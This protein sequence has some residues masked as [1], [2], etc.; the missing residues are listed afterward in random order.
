[1]TIVCSIKKFVSLIKNLNEAQKEALERI[2]FSGLLAMPEITLQRKLCIWLAENFDITSQ[3][4]VIQGKQIPITISDV[5]SIMG[6]PS[7]GVEISTKPALD[8]DDYK[9]YAMYKDSRSSNISLGCLQEAILQDPEA[10]EHFIRRMVLFTIGYI[11]C[12]TTKPYVS[13]DYLSLVKD[14]DK[15]K[16]TNWS[17]LTRDFLLKSLKSYKEGKAN[18]E[19]NLP[20]L[21]FWFWEHVHV[22]EGSYKLSYSNRLPPLM[23]YWNEKNVSSRNKYDIKYGPG[24]G[25]VVF[26]IRIPEDSSEE[27]HSQKE[28][29]EKYY[30]S[31]QQPCSDCPNSTFQNERFETQPRRYTFEQAECGLNPSL[32]EL[33]TQISAHFDLLMDQILQ[34]QRIIQFVDNKLTIKLLSIESTLAKS[35]KDIQELKYSMNM[36][37]R[38]IPADGVDCSDDNIFNEDNLRCSMLQA[39]KENNTMVPTYF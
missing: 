30:H 6:L 5:N 37:T 14:V 21:Q 8:E 34:L 7:E 17:S 32:N 31:M 19:G 36:A 35:R 23:S 33:P 20:F 26:E 29:Y 12:P 2:G 11:L 9:Y 22:E 39:E 28:P 25:K 38:S 24:H 16:S 4:I 3:S 18:L 13:S 1:M 15:I 27:F 10:G